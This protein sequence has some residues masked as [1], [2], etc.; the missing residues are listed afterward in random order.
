[1]YVFLLQVGRGAG[2]GAC[3]GNIQTKKFFPQKDFRTGDIQKPFKIFQAEG[4]GSLL[5]QERGSKRQRWVGF[6]E[7]GKEA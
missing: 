4:K 3:K 6:M 5:I 7:P 2:R 1:M